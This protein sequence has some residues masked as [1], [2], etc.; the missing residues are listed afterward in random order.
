MKI[1]YETRRA[2]RET[3]DAH[4]GCP[5]CRHEDYMLDQA[6]ATLLCPGCHSLPQACRAPAF[7]DH[8]D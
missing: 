5:G 7:F 8:D 3:S 2:A 1:E 4:C 6:G